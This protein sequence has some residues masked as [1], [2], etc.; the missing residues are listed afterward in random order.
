ML[1]F[2]ELSCVD[3]HVLALK[4]RFSGIGELAHMVE[5]TTMY[6]VCFPSHYL[7]GTV[8]VDG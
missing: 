6:C 2:L 7:H 5:H 8:D 1:E 3:I 4:F